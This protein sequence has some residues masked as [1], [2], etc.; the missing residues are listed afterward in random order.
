MHVQTCAALLLSVVGNVLLYVFDCTVKNFNYL[1]V[2][3]RHSF[4]FNCLLKNK[5]EPLCKKSSTHYS[6]TIVKGRTLFSEC[7]PTFPLSPIP[8]VQT[9][10][11]PQT[12]DVHETESFSLNV[13]AVNFTEMSE[14]LPSAHPNGW[15]KQCLS[16]C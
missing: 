4:S 6:C 11:F 10:E 13:F 3:Y 7:I 16:Y 2:P 8:N 9:L 15:H 5:T 14:I 1:P 12:C